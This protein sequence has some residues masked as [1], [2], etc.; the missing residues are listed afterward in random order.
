[1]ANFWKVHMRYLKNHKRIF[2][3][4][5]AASKLISIYWSEVGDLNNLVHLSEDRVDTELDSLLKDR[6]PNESDGTILNWKDSIKYFVWEMEVGDFIMTPAPPNDNRCFLGIIQSGYFF[7]NEDHHRK[8]D[9]IAI[10]SR[11]MLKDKLNNSL[12][13]PR[14]VT[15]L[16][17][18]REEIG[19]LI[20]KF[21]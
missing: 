19:K 1:M 16:N 10:L 11:T 6:H 3:E 15:S 12:G 9:W 13:S 14:S 8:V 18:Y 2:D 17:P 20:L 4:Y 5:N 7:A 21:G